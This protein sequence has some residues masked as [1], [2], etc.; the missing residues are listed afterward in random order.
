MQPLALRTEIERHS[1]DVQSGVTWQFSRRHFGKLIAAGVG[2]LVSAA[3]R[4]LADDRVP[5]PHSFLV[6][7]G[8][9]YIPRINCF[10]MAVLD[11]ET[12]A[13]TKSVTET[14]CL[15]YCSIT[16]VHAT[17]AYFKELIAE[18]LIFGPNKG[19]ADAYYL[20]ITDERWHRFVT[21]RIIPGILEKGFAGLF[22]DTLDSVEFLEATYP[23]EHAGAGRAAVELVR[24]IRHINPKLPI[25]INRGY[26]ILP[27][28][29]GCFDM[30]LGESVHTSFTD[31]GK[32]FRRSEADFIWQRDRMRTAKARDPRIRL[33][34]LDYWDP[35]DPKGI[36]QIYYEARRNGF[37]PYV[38]TS[39]L[40]TIVPPPDTVCR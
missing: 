15:G 6:Y 30:L 24:R 27:Q 1:A 13:A 26:K 29:S 31:S 22:L 35:H 32:Y 9:A 28:I 17:R 14:T 25:M 7:Y 10:D 2:A 19:W 8:D 3:R 20:N 4:T 37:V 34:S 36:A 12:E 38:G 16:E 40:T 33:F 11:P 21:E 39:D 23:L 18:G 5:R